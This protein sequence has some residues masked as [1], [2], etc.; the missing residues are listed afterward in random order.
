MGTFWVPIGPVWASIECFCGPIRGFVSAEG[1]LEI[2][3][4]SQEFLWLAQRG[5][6]ARFE[7]QLDLFGLEL[8]VSV[9]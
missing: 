4:Y 1:S 2:P 9:A 7:S 6:W 5:Q 3:D 8:G